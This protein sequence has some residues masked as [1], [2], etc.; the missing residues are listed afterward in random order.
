MH[1]SGLGALVVWLE[2]GS[3]MAVLGEAAVGKGACAQ[4]LA[5]VLEGA[6]V[7]ICV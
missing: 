1:E 5:L 4:G 2:A 7:L 6:L 3:L